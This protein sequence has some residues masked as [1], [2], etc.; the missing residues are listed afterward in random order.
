MINGIINVRKEKGMTSF[1][2]IYRLRKIFGQKKIGHTGTLDPEAEGVLPVC[3]G[4]ATRLVSMLTGETKSYEAVLLL[5]ITTDTQDM[6]G[7]VLSEKKAEASEAEAR[8][9]LF[10]F[11]GKQMQLPP[12]YSA[13][14][15]GGRKLVDLA[16][17]GVEVERQPREVEFTD[18]NILEMNLPRIRFSVTCTKGSFIRTLCS[19]IGEKLGCGGVM[20]SLIRTRVGNF[21]IEDSLTLDEIRSRK[22]EEDRITRNAASPYSFLIPLE[23][24]FSGLP[25]VDGDPSLDRAL[26][27]GN[28]FAKES[29]LP[30]GQEVRVHTSTGRFIGIYRFAE[31]AGMFRLVKNFYDPD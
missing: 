24:M 27:N 17:K 4:K 3:M 19:D 13:V 28:D 7:K 2:V 18:M 1:D 26:I 22:E 8:A 21:R 12:M 29:S 31:D 23:D 10:S 9:V 14:K 30:D 16:R 5:G 11:E 20:E 15:I 6:T 25:S